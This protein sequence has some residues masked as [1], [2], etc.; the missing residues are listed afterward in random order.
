MMK[1]GRAGTAGSRRRNSCGRVHV[2]VL[3]RVAASRGAIPA[4]RR[5]RSRAT[6]NKAGLRR[7]RLAPTPP[8]KAGFADIA[9]DFQSRRGAAR[10][11]A[12]VAQNL[13]AHPAAA[14][15]V[16]TTRRHVRLLGQAATKTKQP[17]LS[18]KLQ[19]HWPKT[20]ATPLETK[21]NLRDVRTGGEAKRRGYQSFFPHRS[22]HRSGTVDASFLLCS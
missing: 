4:T 17:A 12:F 22:K 11:G 18:A 21:W 15:P 8:A 7:L 6:A 20:V 13:D 19:A 16:D 14:S 1:V 9:R 10:R 5:P 3:W 2:R